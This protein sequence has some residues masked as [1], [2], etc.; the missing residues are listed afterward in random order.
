[1]EFFVTKDIKWS[2]VNPLNHAIRN[3]YVSNLLNLVFSVVDKCKNNSGLKIT[4][5]FICGKLVESVIRDDELRSFS[6]E[7]RCLG[8]T[9]DG[10]SVD[11]FVKTAKELKSIGIG[12]Y[13]TVSGFYAILNGDCIKI[14]HDKS[15]IVLDR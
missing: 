12:V 4:N 10:Y 7:G 1:M 14:Q 13:L 2:D 3:E 11:S 6:K 9:F 8:F 15:W 5:G